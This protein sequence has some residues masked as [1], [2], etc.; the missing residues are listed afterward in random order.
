V[1]LVAGE[2]FRFTL[3]GPGL[4]TWLPGFLGQL[5]G[6]RSLDEA[7]ATLSPAHQAAARHLLESLGGERLLTEGP[8]ELAPRPVSLAL[9][10]EG[11]GALRAAVDRLACP[12][13]AHAPGSPG[14]RVLCQDTL[15]LN[16]ALAFNERCLKG[17][18]PWLWLTCAPLSRAY[19][20][21]VF[22]PDAGPCLA[23]LVGHF[24]R[25][26][27]FPAL[28]DELVQHGCEGGTFAPAHFPESGLD[29]LAHL[30]RG[31]VDLLARPEPAATAF[32]L[33]VLEVA[34]LEVSSHPVL[35]DPECRA[36][37]RRR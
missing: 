2:E 31:K 4:E 28:Y 21:P 35:L 29:V 18:S 36:C 11:T 14:V 37:R 1:R 13:V 19:V 32:R 16:E 5:D 8:L 27:P 20:S 22:L 33:H 12:P 26:S 34:T 7:L 23:C 6:R 9:L 24:R 15:D 30:A 3:S 25:L 17:P 10:P